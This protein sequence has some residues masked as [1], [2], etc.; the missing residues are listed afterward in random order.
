M[1]G[2]LA[3]LGSCVMALQSRHHSPFILQSSRW[4]GLTHIIKINEL[5][6]FHDWD[7]WGVWTRWQEWV[8]NK[9]EAGGT[10]F[11]P[12]A[13]FPLINRSNKARIP[14]ILLQTYTYSTHVVHNIGW[15]KTLTRVSFV[16][17]Q[18]IIIAPKERAI[19]PFYAY[20]GGSPALPP[21]PPLL[22]FTQRRDCQSQTIQNHLVLFQVLPLWWPT[23]H[24]P[25]PLPN[26]KKTLV[27]SLP[28]LILLTLVPLNQHH[29]I[30]RKWGLNYMPQYNQSWVLLTVRWLL[31]LNPRCA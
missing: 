27:F 2:W 7:Y 23:P 16:K 13:L 21:N 11:P 14:G 20:N 8:G 31:F 4:A 22:G 30:Y 17:F 19:G 5:Y 12:P 9:A 10:F 29:F 1:T 26:F 24:S 6:W 28:I 3:G 25:L 18:I 15:L